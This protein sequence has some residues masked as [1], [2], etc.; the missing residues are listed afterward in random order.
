MSWQRVVIIT[1]LTTGAVV[2]GIFGNDE[3]VRMIAASLAGAAGG[4]AVPGTSRQ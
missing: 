3:A 2:L 4:I 1:V